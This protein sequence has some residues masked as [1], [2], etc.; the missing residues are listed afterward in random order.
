MPGGTLQY[1]PGINRGVELMTAQYR[2][3]CSGI[4]ARKDEETDLIAID[5][6]STPC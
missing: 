2:N 6:D 1:S 4:L 3:V 5:R